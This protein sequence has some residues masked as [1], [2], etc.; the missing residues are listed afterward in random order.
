MEELLQLPDS[1]NAM[2]RSTIADFLLRLASVRGM[3][4]LLQLPDSW[5]A[6]LR[7]TTADFLPR[8]ASEGN[9]RTPAV[10]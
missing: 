9:G 5:N 1:W 4:E 8:L 6:M 10:A 2:L 3:E 7:C